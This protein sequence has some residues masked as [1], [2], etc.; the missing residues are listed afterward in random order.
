M[1]RL[2]VGDRVYMAG[3]GFGKGTVR[4]VGRDNEAGQQFMVTVEWDGFPGQLSRPFVG[5]L[6]LIEYMPHRVIELSI[7]EAISPVCIAQTFASKSEAVHYL[8][9]VLRDPEGE[10]HL[11]F[12]VDQQGDAL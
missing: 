9:T 5:D 7:V 1:R 4:E 8:V 10:R 12:P 3:A 11:I 6:V 2:V